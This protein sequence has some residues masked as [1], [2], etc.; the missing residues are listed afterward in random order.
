[1][2]GFTTEAKVGVFVLV[3]LFLLAYMSFRI[4][5]FD[6]GRDKGY[7]VYAL[8]DNAT[9]LKKDVTVEIAGIE[10]GQVEGI[11]LFKD[12]ARV[13]LRIASTVPLAMDCRAL[14]RTKG[15]LGDKYIE[16]VPGSRGVPVL[17]DGGRIV[18]AASPTDVDQIISKIGDISDD[19]KKVTQTLGSVLGGEEGAGQLRQILGNFSE[20]SE[21][22]AK[23]TRENNVQLQKMIEN[24]T[25]FSTDLRDV[26]TG[27]KQNINAILASFADTAQ[28]M[29]HT[30]AALQQ[31]SERIRRGEGSLGKLVTDDTTV[32]H[33][34]EALA[35]LKSISTKI[36]QGAGTLGKLVNDSTTGERLDAALEGVNDYLAK[37]EAFKVFVDYRGDYLIEHQELKSTLNVRIQP[38][39]EKYYLIGVTADTYGRYEKKDRT[40]TR[41]GVATQVTEETWER[42][43][44]KFNAQIAKRYYDFVVRGG[45]IESGGG[46]GLDYYMLDDDLQFTFEAFTGEVDRNPHLRVAAYYTFLKFFYISLGYDDFISDR[47]RESPF[48]GIGIKFNDDDLKYLLSSAPIPTG[49]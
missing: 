19:I 20:M 18:K 33:L 31:I 12:K 42:G 40:I 11:S 32:R 38:S 43:Q 25:V 9:G 45:L 21:S 24:L 2:A 48:V 36:D 23:L 47:D 5:G 22:L 4:G 46:F 3:G 35:S 6:I 16:I 10:V 27:N 14:I 44:L 1:M 28:K 37:N 39:A 34:D 15:V 49:N 29:N 41:G 30:I 13:D 7:T 26:S 8:F 17:K